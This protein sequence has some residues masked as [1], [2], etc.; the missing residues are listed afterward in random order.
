MEPRCSR[1]EALDILSRV[2]EQLNSLDMLRLNKHEM[3]WPAGLYATPTVPRSL[4]VLVHSPHAHVVP[5]ILPLGHILV[6]PLAPSA[7]TE[8][9]GHG[10][11][12]PSRWRPVLIDFERSTP[13]A[14]KP[15]NM[16]QVLGRVLPGQT[17]TFGARQ[18]PVPAAADRSDTCPAC[19]TDLFSTPSSL[20]L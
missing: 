6:S 16:T 8:G 19:P 15:S 14:V 2:L 18:L 17:G 9:P 4:F 1:E 13:G 7:A 3:N 11:G 5:Y 10:P 12:C 20:C